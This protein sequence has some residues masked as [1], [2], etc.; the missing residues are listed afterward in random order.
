V[1][2]SKGDMVGC[3]TADW[4]LGRGHRVTVVTP[5]RFAGRLIEPI[6][7]RLLHQ[8]LLD[9]GAEIF[10]DTEVI[11]LTEE[12]MVIRHLVSGRESAMTKVNTL[13][14]ACGARANDELHLELL[15]TAPELEVHIAGDAASPRYIE[16]AIYEGHMI[17]R[18]L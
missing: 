15:M 11:R 14:A 7:W 18:A 9:Q 6:T 12:G 1:F 17:A 8:R 3:T 2:D 13:V 5:H 10:V 4:L 16:Q